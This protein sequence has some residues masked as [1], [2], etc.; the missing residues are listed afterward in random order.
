MCQVRALSTPGGQSSTAPRRVVLLRISR[1]LFVQSSDWRDR[2]QASDNYH[3]FRILSFSS[4][5]EGTAAA[6]AVQ[7]EEEEG[8]SPREETKFTPSC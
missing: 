6:A 3:L 5:Q 4:G 8:L 1:P 7:E 2:R